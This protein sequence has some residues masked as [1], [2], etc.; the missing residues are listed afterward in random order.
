MAYLQASQFSVYGF[1]GSGLSSTGV[2][3]SAFFSASKALRCG[4]SHA[5]GFVD[6]VSSVSGSAILL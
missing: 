4:C 1:E 6:F 2:E 5:N 3:H